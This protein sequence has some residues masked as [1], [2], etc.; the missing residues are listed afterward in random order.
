MNL[1]TS[2]I[3]N[4]LVIKVADSRIDASVSVEFKEHMKALT[5]G[6]GDRVIL[7][8]G[9]VKFIDSSGLGAV[10]SAMKLMGQDRKLELADLQPVVVKVFNLTRMDTVFTIHP[11]VAA[12]ADA[13]TQAG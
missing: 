6:A 1:S 8:L 3:G 7:D 4:V 11:N 9:N 2:E 10:V 13:A 5:E 12:V